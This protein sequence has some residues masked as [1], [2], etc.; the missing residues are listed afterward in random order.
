MRGDLQTTGMTRPRTVVWMAI[1]IAVAARLFFDWTAPLL[2]QHAFRQTQTAMTVYWF[3]RDG[4]DL[5]RPPLPVFGVEA[6]SLPL[7]FPLYQA[8]VATV[9]DLIGA[10]SVEAVA[11]GC[12]AV[13]FAF[14]LLAAW[15][16]HRLARRHFSPLVADGAVLIWLT[17]PYAV[18]WSTT[19]MIESTAVALTLIH[20]DQVERAALSVGGRKAGHA[21]AAMI[22][23]ALAAVVKVTTFALYLPA[24][25]LLYV[26]ARRLW[27]P[28][29]WR[30]SDILAVLA[31][32]VVPIAVVLAW[33]TWADAVKA[34]NAFGG[35]GLLSSTLMEWNFGTWMQRRS[36]EVWRTIG[37]CLFGIV[38][39]IPVT[40]AAA[41][42]AVRALGCFSRGIW[43]T[44][45]PLGP[46][47]F[48]NLY[49][50]HDYYFFAV[51]PPLAM[52]AAFGA[53][54]A[55][56]AIGRSTAL[57]TAALLILVGTAWVDAAYRWRPRPSRPA[58]VPVHYLMSRILPHA[59]L[60]AD[61][62]LT[63]EIARHIRES[64]RP[65]GPIVITGNDWSPDIALYAERPAYMIGK[66][67]NHIMGGCSP[68]HWE[69]VR[70][71]KPALFVVLKPGTDECP[72]GLPAPECTLIDAPAY[73][74]GT[75]MPGAR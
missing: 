57:C 31:A 44:I 21:A 10:R 27:S 45:V 60:P 72:E 15:P 14:H 11:A 64:G 73:W 38:L 49:Y 40:V 43:I 66:P 30:L 55:A 52:L 62:L 74:I 34:E 1:G 12:R 28:L 23:G 54:T 6:P 37:L 56:A 51:L 32:F 24:A 75:C 19:A 8:I 58:T 47:V 61:A 17:L 9:L 71:A 53:C 2:D 5:L 22:A 63:L 13:S 16:L 46:L 68:R 20:V 70:H 7:E 33:T 3:L 42:G 50:L 18:F 29:A 69:M 39:G 65:P 26:A 25:G 67:P 35:I 41:I 36:G 59:G 4:I 48:I